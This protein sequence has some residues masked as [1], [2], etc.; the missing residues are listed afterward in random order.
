[1]SILLDAIKR[2]QKDQSTNQM[3]HISYQIK[4]PL[5]KSK[6][7]TRKWLGLFFFFG[8]STGCIITWYQVK[9]ESMRDVNQWMTQQRVQQKQI[10]KKPDIELGQ[11]V[12]IMQPKPLT[13]KV[14][15]SNFDALRAQVEAQTEKKKQQLRRIKNESK[16]LP[17]STA[18]AVPT[19][20]II[21]KALKT[22]QD[23]KRKIQQT[24]SNTAPKAQTQNLIGTLEQQ[25]EYDQ[26]TLAL[27]KSF[28][29]AIE[30]S[31]LNQKTTSMYKTYPK[32]Q[33]GILQ[34]Y[35]KLPEQLQRALP[36]LKINAHNFSSNPKKRFLVIG[37]RSVYEGQQITED[38]QL[39]KVRHH[40][41]VYSFRNVKFRAP[42]LETWSV[43]K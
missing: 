27:I 4:H 25:A 10:I 29:K 28:E 1:M 11:K 35:N 33:R 30:E 38:L 41:A 39:I 16:T 17:I 22:K 34:H 23:V 6:N 24:I 12:K 42:A 20:P 7:A 13:P 26:Q 3:P 19:Q 2:A 37:R 32:A 18:T 9:P 31:E 36:E 15:P 5:S 14:K 8:L 43:K 21:S 40:D